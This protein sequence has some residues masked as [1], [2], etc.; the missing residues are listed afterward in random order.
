MSTNNPQGK[1]VTPPKE[2]KDLYLAAALH[3]EGCKYLGID[4]TDP[5]R[6][7]FQF[8]GGELADTTERHWYQATCVGSL[9][10]YAQSI[11]TMKS[12]IHS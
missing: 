2:T 11:R 7:I 12:L 4:K 5:T 6:M 3:S 1:V 9:T 10:S 8:E